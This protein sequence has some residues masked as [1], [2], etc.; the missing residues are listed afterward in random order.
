MRT[1]GLEIRIGLHAGEYKLS[2]PDIIVSSDA[3]RKLGLVFHELTTNAMKHGALAKPDG[4]VN[5]SCEPE[6]DKIQLGVQGLGE[7]N[8]I[9]VAAS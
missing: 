5:V 9:V 3:A 2:G 6:G 8:Q 1:L 7:Q 4:R